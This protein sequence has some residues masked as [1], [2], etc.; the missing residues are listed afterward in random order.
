MNIYIPNQEALPRLNRLHAPEAFIQ[1]VWKRAAKRVHRGFRN[2]QRSFPKA[3]HL[4]KTVA[5]IG[6][7]VGDKDTVDAIDV[8]FDG[9]EPRESFAFSEAAVHKESGALRLEQGDV[10]RAA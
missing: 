2:V 8:Q 10:A 7:F 4:R 6:V 1:G 5:V 9:R 3:E